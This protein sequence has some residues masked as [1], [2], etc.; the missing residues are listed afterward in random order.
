[1]KALEI[2]TPM[3]F[4]FANNNILSYFFFV[5]LIIELY[6]LNVAVIAQIFN[7]TAETVS[8]WENQ[9]KKQNEKLKYIQ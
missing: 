8:L 2:K 9:L 6:F 4:N 7:L 3:V 5:S 1:M